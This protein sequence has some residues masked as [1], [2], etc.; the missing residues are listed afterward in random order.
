MELPVQEPCPLCETVQ[1]HAW[2]YGGREQ[3]SAVIIE[4]DL[5]LAFIRDDRLN[6]YSFVIPKRHVPFITDLHSDETT[7]IMAMVHQIARAIVAEFSPDGL[8]VFQNNG[9]VA[10]QTTPHVHFHLAPR[11][12]KEMATWNPDEDRW[13]GRIQ[14]IEARRELARRLSAYRRVA[15]G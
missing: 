10:N 1:R 5:A 7:A 12:A 6:G 9:V 15:R 13:S 11:S 2:T 4:D 3:P 8:N 14:P